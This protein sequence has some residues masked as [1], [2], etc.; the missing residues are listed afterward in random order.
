VNSLL[1]G[2][3]LALYFNP[4]WFIWGISATIILLGTLYWVIE[5]IQPMRK[6]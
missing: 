1:A 2:I 4:Q 3:A 5:T 6:K